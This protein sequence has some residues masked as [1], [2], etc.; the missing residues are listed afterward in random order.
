MMKLAVGTWHD[1][2]R[3]TRTIIAWLDEYTPSGN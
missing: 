2:A 1:A 3:L